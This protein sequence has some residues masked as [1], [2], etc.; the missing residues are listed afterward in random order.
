M[1][2][3]TTLFSILLAMACPLAGC[4]T[5]EDRMPPPSIDARIDQLMERYD[6]AV[7][8]ASLLVVRDGEAVVQRGYG[9]SDLEQGVEAGPATNYRLASVSKQFTAA[10]ILLL[11]QD[12]KLGLDDPVRQWLPSL[13]HAADAIT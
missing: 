6:G 1:R 3:P 10:A 12:G 7:P 11:A 9:L 4:A 8:G 5:G 13:P 2:S